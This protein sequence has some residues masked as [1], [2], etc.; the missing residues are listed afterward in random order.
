MIPQ[1]RFHRLK[2][3]TGKVS[4][5][6][7]CFVPHSKTL[8]EKLCFNASGARVIVKTLASMTT[9]FA[10]CLGAPDKIVTNMKITIV[11]QHKKFQSSQDY[12]QASLMSV[13]EK[14]VPR[15]GCASQDC[16]AT[17]GSRGWRGAAARA[18]ISST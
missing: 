8:I 11:Q 12:K 13:A 14:P 5:I 1:L 4:N 9:Y 7:G 2:S 16:Q 3:T 15:M 6:Y 10:E 17:S 18:G